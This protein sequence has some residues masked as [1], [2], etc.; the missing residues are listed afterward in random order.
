M[1]K[2]HYAMI[3]DFNSRGGTDYKAWTHKINTHGIGKKNSNGKLTLLSTKS[4]HFQEV[5]SAKTR[6]QDLL[7]APKI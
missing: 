6:K 3:E 4:C 2:A 1:R 5:L 7:D